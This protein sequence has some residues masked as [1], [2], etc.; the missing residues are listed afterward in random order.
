MKKGDTAADDP[1][2]IYL[3]PHFS[4]KTIHKMFVTACETRVDAFL[5]DEEITIE[6]LHER[7]DPFP[8][9]I[10]YDKL[11][12][13]SYS[14]FRAQWRESF[15]HVRFF[16]AVWGECDKCRKFQVGAYGR[17]HANSSAPVHEEEQQEDGELDLSDMDLSDIEAEEE[18]EGIDG[19]LDSEL[20]ERTALLRLDAAEN[21]EQVEEVLT[22]FNHH[23]ERQNEE[24]NEH[25]AHAQERRHGY[26]SEL[27]RSRTEYAECK[28]EQRAPEDYTP[29]F[30]FDF[31][32]SLWLPEDIEKV[33]AFDFNNI[34]RVR[35]FGVLDD[36]AKHQCNFL[37]WEY[38]TTGNG[39]S[40]I[41]LLDKYVIAGVC[42]NNF[43][44]L[45]PLT[46]INHI[47]SQIL[48][49]AL[50]PEALPLAI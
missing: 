49:R 37:F 4:Q 7:R 5:Q 26:S 13:Y 50:S 23:R 20:L 10:R 19:R 40:T 22:H 21:E 38:Y 6:E 33:T 2:T 18:E 47:C 24:W 43:V 14:G 48:A 11:M 35:C 12:T 31:A 9:G 39:N 30:T 29:H 42:I 16:H 27:H 1:A 3:P 15:R 44:K 17:R 8:D 28:N 45:F 34:R 25:L 46:Y 41:S 32:A 36:G